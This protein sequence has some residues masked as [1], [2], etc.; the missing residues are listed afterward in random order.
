MLKVRLAVAS[1]GIAMMLPASSALFAQPAEA[2]A[3]PIPSQIFT[4]K[5]IFISN[6]GANFDTNLW[7]G[8][9][10]RTYSEFY[11]A[12]RNWGKYELVSFPNEAD[13]VLDIRLEGTPFPYAQFRL[14][15]LDPKTHV[16]L[17]TL[18]E[19]F[20]AAGLKKSRDKKFD[21]SIDALVGDLKALTAQPS[22]PN[23]T[24]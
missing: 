6:A 14:V 4:A 3:A 5:K 22:A 11:L 16:A 20:A 15:L 24:K 1:L 19:R 23:A 17:W 9:P 21:D 18:S 10:D 13:M 2:P 7:S 12:I 8:T